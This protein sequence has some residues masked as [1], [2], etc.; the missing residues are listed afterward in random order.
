MKKFV[1]TTVF[2]LVL[3]VV[4]LMLSSVAGATDKTETWVLGGMKSYHTDR[5]KL[6]NESHKGLGVELQ[7]GWSFGY[8]ENSYFKD[9]FTLTKSF[10]QWSYKKVSLGAKIGIVSGYNFPIGV[11]IGG[12]RLTP[13]VVPTLFIDTTPVG[14]DIYITPS[15]VA[16]Q[17][18]V[19]F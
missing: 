5:T 14:L 10:R 1:K 18:K 4:W 2:V 12:T 7:N 19:N 6:W 15:V 9:S 17:V 3:V 13:V 11:G 8:Y 16:A